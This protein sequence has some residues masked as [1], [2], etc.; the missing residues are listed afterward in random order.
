MIGTIALQCVKDFFHIEKKADHLIREQ[1]P[2]EGYVKN[3]KLFLKT[4]DQA[5]KIEIFK[6]KKQL[7]LVINQQLQT[8]GYHH[9]LDDIFLK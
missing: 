3:S 1:E 2:V 5:L 8:L 7:L 4:S 9:Q 6:Q